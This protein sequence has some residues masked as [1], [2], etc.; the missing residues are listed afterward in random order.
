MSDTRKMLG[1]ISQSISKAD[2][3]LGG[4]PAGR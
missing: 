1:D 2:Q 3:K 4:R